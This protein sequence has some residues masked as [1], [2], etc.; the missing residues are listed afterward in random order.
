MLLAVRHSTFCVLSNDAFRQTF[1]T[2]KAD[3]KRRAGMTFFRYL[4]QIITTSQ[5]LKSSDISVGDPIFQMNFTCSGDT[6][7]V[8]LQKLRVKHRFFGKH[9]L[10]SSLSADTRYRFMQ[11]LTDKVVAPFHLNIM[12]EFWIFH[13]SVQYQPRWL[14]LSVSVECLAFFD[15]TAFRMV[16][17]FISVPIV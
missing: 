11:I 7:D 3:L 13:Y 6:I 1:V 8:F 4:K 16:L 14:L 12:P 15:S 17:I 10:I 9:N 5:L 2:S